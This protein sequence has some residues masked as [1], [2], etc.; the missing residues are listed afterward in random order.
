MYNGKS[1]EQLTK[2][3]FISIKKA[4]K[5]YEIPLTAI[6]VKTKLKLV[7]SSIL[8]F[9]DGGCNIQI[10]TRNSVVVNKMELHHLSSSDQLDLSQISSYLSTNTWTSWD[11][12]CKL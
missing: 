1:K 7:I 11:L 9:R 5:C 3:S 8:W 2:K 12:N 4:S 10:S 6:L